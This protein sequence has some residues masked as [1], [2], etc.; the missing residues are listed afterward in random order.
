M[1]I[2]HLRRPRAGLH[3]QLSIGLKLVDFSIGLILVNSHVV[4]CA[5]LLLSSKGH[6][7]KSIA[8]GHSYM[9]FRTGHGCLI[10]ET[11]TAL[12]NHKAAG[13]WMAWARIHMRKLSGILH[14]P[15]AGRF[16][17][18]I[19]LKQVDFELFFPGACE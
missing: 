10:S 12:G 17:W 2:A 13:A 3:S 15:D 1:V 19:G 7:P 14:W 6:K 5:A 8:L 18:S 16:Y 9:W 4:S 11:P